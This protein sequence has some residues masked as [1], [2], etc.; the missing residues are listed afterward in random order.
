MLDLLG[1]A[2]YGG[3]FAGLCSNCPGCPKGY[4]EHLQCF[5]T[6][7]EFRGGGRPL[8]SNAAA[9]LWHVGDGVLCAE[10]HSK[11]NT[12]NADTL[13][14]LMGAVDEAERGDWAGLVIGNSADNFSA[15]YGFASAGNTLHT[16]WPSRS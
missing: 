10:F 2:A 3:H 5:I 14:L 12:I 15:G 16:S 7:D 6:L 13:D 1:R 9:C 11:M 4:A 8:L